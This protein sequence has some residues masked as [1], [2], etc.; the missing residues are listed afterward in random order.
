MIDGGADPNEAREYVGTPLHFA[1]LGGEKEV[2]VQT[3]LER[4]ADPNKGNEEEYSP[5]GK[6]RQCCYTE[7][8]KILEEAGGVI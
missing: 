5:L 4:G 2:V 6:A 8:A 1:V 3:L 7:I